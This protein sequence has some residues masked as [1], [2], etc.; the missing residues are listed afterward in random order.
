MHFLPVPGI[1]LFLSTRRGVN[2]NTFAPGARL[3]RRAGLLFAGSFGLQRRRNLQNN[4]VGSETIKMPVLM[5][6]EKKS[7]APLSH[8]QNS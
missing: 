3:G 7:L 1:Y 4:I 6:W 5:Q 8:C 2:E